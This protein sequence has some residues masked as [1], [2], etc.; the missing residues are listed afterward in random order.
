MPTTTYAHGTESESF[1]KINQLSPPASAFEIGGVTPTAFSVAQDIAPESYLANE[2]I[3]F[4]IDLEQ[5]KLTYPEQ[6]LN[7]IKFE[8]DFGDGQKAQGI[9]NTHQYSKIGSYVLS[10]VADFNNPQVP[11]VLAESVLINIVPDAN[12]QIP[13]P[14]IKINEQETKEPLK[15]T[16]SLDLNKPV[17]FEV[18]V[19]NST[20]Q[21]T[22]I[23]WDF[24]NGKTSNQASVSFR[25]QL[26]Q[27]YV[28]PAV[29]VKDANGFIAYTFADITNSGPNNPNN[30]V[31]EDFKDSIVMII[32]IVIA[33]IVIIA[34]FMFFKR[35]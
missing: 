26:P 7:Q 3:N 25:Y 15:Q 21:I 10:I 18:H 32:V 23:L 16:F 35:R 24:G 17:R 31:F 14:V 8:W 2:P 28:S 19:P 9:K 20:S 30:P 27:Y 33:L 29:Q 6:A 22:E 5:V 1:F 11:P 34:G 13:K 4:E 12:Y